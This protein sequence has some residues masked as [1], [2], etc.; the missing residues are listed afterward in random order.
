M[1]LDDNERAYL[2]AYAAVDP[3]MWA[4][5]WSL[6][7]QAK[8]H[9]ADVVACSFNGAVAV[10]RRLGQRKLLDGNDERGK[11]RGYSIT[12]KGKEALANASN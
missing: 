12:D 5:P 7:V 8:E 10:G 11:W 3:E 1:K 2:T 9:G 6:T 4:T